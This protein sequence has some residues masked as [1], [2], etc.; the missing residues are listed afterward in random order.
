ME[1]FALTSGKGKGWGG[2]R[3]AFNLLSLVSRRD[4]R[5]VGS[6]TQ[7][8][9]HQGEHIE[10]TIEKKENTRLKVTN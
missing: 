9:I 10:K 4:A 6:I 7:K 3:G 1:R 5:D 2:E 8:G